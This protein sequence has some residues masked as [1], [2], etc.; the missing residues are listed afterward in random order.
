M[1]RS[2]VKPRAAWEPIHQTGSGFPVIAVSYESTPRSLGRVRLQID[3]LRP[4]LGSDVTDDVLLV[5]SELASN[6]VRQSI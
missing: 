3:L 4:S 6:A 5:A 2:D 1:Q